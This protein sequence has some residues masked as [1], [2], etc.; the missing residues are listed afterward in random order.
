MVFSGYMPSSG[1]AGLCGS[2]ARQFLKIRAHSSE[3][4]KVLALITFTLSLGETGYMLKEKISDRNIY[5][6]KN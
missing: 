5:C 1:I 4:D 6:A 2:F 3:K